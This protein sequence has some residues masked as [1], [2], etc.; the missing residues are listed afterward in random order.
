MVEKIDKMSTS[1]P[2]GTLIDLQFEQQPVAQIPSDHMIDTPGEIVS[3]SDEEMPE[4]QNKLVNIKGID[5]IKYQL[6]NSDTLVGLS[7]RFN[8][9]VRNF[10][11]YSYS[12]TIF[13][14]KELRTINK[15]STDEQMWGKGYILIPYRGQ[16]LAQHTPEQLRRLAEQARLRKLSKFQRT[17]KCNQ[18]EAIY[19]L[20]VCN[21]DYDFA[22][23]EYEEDLKWEKKVPMPI[24][25]SKKCNI[26]K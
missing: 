16:G 20:D 8:V 1:P 12:L 15:L 22:I 4:F 26:M 5:Y 7:L 14:T 9:T 11:L 21:W 6:L 10:I 3:S 25:L 18:K 24:P 19:Y 2:Q 13:K 17:T 23:H